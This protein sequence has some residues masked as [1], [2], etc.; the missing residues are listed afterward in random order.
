MK[1]LPNGDWLYLRNLPI[2]TSDES[3]SA[4]FRE[5][6]LDIG[7]ERI[8]VKIYGAESV[9][10]PTAAAFV[11]VS[12]DVVLAL[13]QWVLNGDAVDGRVPRVE[14]ARTKAR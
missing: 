3:L 11:S 14:L 12:K 7:P 9:Q 8:S 6:G 13:V 10:E 4:Y 2:T 5:R 1:I